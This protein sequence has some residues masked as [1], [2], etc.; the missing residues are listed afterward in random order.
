MVLQ[1]CHSGITSVYVCACVFVRV[2]LCE[3]VCV[4]VCVF[5][6]TNPFGLL[7]AVTHHYSVCMCVCVCVCVCKRGTSLQHWCRGAT[8]M[9]MESNG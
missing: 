2:Y 1:W 4:C 8:V 6:T 5:S 3:C 7:H 9:V